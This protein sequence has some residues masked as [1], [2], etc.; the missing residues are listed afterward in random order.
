MID[1]QKLYDV[2]LNPNH[3][4][5]SANL[6]WFVNRI[7]EVV[8]KSFSESGKARPPRLRA[9]NFGKK[10]RELWFEFNQKRL[11][12]DGVISQIE[13]GGEIDDI[14]TNFI[15]GDTYMKFLNGDI[16]EAILI[17]LMKEAGY[18]VDVSQPE[19]NVNDVTGHPDCIV[20]HTDGTTEVIDTKSASRFAFGPKFV[21]GGL[22][23]GDDAFGYVGQN[24]H[25]RQA[26]K[27][28][29]SGWL[30]ANKDT[31]ELAYLELPREKEIDAHKRIDYLKD[32][33]RKPEPPPELCHPLEQDKDGNTKIGKGCGY[34]VFKH[35]CHEGLRGFKHNGKWT[36][37]TNIVKE[38]KGVE[39][40]ADAEYYAEEE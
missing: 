11:G 36:Y 17:L 40:K 3:K 23:N 12:M 25:Y 24:S 5:D 6:E 8:V 37:Y 27:A 9:S 7:R 16:I 14:N 34:C 35:Q 38:P 28:N 29:T 21:D 26:T 19:L 33:L 31:G 20:T 15:S 2:F 1:V 4:L 39:W 13:H 32:I 22:I 10:D 18:S 30:A